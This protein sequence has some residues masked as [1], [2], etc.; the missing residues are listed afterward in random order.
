MRVFRQFLRLAIAAIST[1]AIVVPGEARAQ[2]SEQGPG[3]PTVL[4]EVRDIKSRMAVLQSA[5][6][7]LQDSLNNLASGTSLDDVVTEVTN[8]GSN[9]RLIPPSWSQK[10][11]AAERFEL[12]LDGAAVLDHESGLVWEKAPS[13]FTYKFVDTAF[14][15]C[16][17]K[18]IGGR[19]GWRVPTMW[20]MLTLVD[21]ARSNP[22]LPEG[23]PFTNLKLANYWTATPFSVGF[24]H[25]TAYAVGVDDGVPGTTGVD[26]VFSVW[27][28]RAPGGVNPVNPKSP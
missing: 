2:G 1:I 8:V 10:L 5:L 28:V 23:H 20:E 27:C 17:A 13:A 22:A 16:N 6:T 3:N 11:P 26:Q 21:P 9:L 18:N 25:E 12:V 15:G 14:F 7:A 19:R 4:A 24:L